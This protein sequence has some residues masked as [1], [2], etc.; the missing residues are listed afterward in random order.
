MRSLITPF[1]TAVTLACALP[2]HAQGGPQLAPPLFS[3]LTWR[4]IGPTSISGRVNDIAVGRVRGAPDHIYVGF[5]GGVWKSV[6]GG[7]SWVP[8]FDNVDAYTS[9]GAL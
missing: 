8:V 9:V 5:G 7:T 4:N 3:S 1:T 6:N 2:L